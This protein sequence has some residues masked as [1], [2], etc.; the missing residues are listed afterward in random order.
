MSCKVFSGEF[1]SLDDSSKYLSTFTKR[2]GGGWVYSSGCVDGLDSSLELWLF[3][4]PANRVKCL[5]YQKQNVT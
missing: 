4:A 1:E 3:K 5:N 2:L